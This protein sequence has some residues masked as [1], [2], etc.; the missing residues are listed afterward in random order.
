MKRSYGI[1]LYLVSLALSFVAGSMLVLFVFGLIDRWLNPPDVVGQDYT[2]FGLGMCM[3]FI[4]LP[5]LVIITA[6]CTPI[7]HSRL[8]TLVNRWL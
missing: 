8:K 1:A 4:G 3:E 7:I 2:D 6:A 5:V